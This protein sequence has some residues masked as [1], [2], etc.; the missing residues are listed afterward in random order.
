MPNGNTVNVLLVEDD[1]VD[2]KVVHRAFAKHRIAN[3]I[4]EARDGIEALEIMRGENGNAPLQR[5]YLV[6]LDLNMPR[7]NG[8]EFLREIRRDD[9]LQDSLIFVL[10]TS[11]EE[12]DRVQAYL[13]NVAGYMVKSDAGA[14]FVN[15]VELLDHYWKVVKFPM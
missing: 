14:D 6:L 8:M 13:L 3:P 7:M 12:K 10:T 15:A 11:R 5:P 2:R 4:I 1:E 9:H